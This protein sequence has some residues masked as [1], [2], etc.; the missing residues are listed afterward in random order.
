M[1]RALFK[2]LL[3]VL[4]LSG[5][6]SFGALR[7]EAQTGP[8]VEA[9]ITGQ[10]AAFQDDDFEAAFDFAS[11]SIRMIFQT[12]QRFGEMVQQG[13]PMVHRP[14]SVRF[15]ERRER[16]GFVLQ[17][18]MIGDAAGRLHLLEYQML[19]TDSGFLINGVRL[20][21]PAGTGV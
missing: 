8:A 13:Y 9:V 3:P 5:L 21:P 17:R 1:L 18:V 11:P 7:A 19:Q 6:M 15:L 4:A 14:D 10:I 20:L 16:R 2:H 12:P